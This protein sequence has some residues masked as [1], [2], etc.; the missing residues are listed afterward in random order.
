MVS[1]LHVYFPLISDYD[2]VFKEISRKVYTRHQKG[3]ALGQE[4][5]Q[6]FEISYPMLR[7]YR[8]N[9]FLGNLFNNSE[10]NYSAY[11]HPKS[12]SP[13]RGTSI[14]LPF[15]RSGR[16]GWGMRVDPPLG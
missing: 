16:R 4:S 3:E 5:V 6:P 13:G 11:P 2:D 8:G 15:S 7:P 9:I 10:C 12:L 14:R 1:T